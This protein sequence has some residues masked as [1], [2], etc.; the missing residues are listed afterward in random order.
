MPNMNAEIVVQLV[1]KKEHIE[2]GVR[3]VSSIMK[4]DLVMR[5]RMSKKIRT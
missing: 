4:E 2:V 1:K 5:Y 3:Q